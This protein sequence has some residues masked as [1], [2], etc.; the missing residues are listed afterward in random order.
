MDFCL[1]G[2]VK[3]TS[4]RLQI[5]GTTMKIPKTFALAFLIFAVILIVS[6]ML[7]RPAT[8]R[9]ADVASE[10]S[11]G[12][13]TV[14]VVADGLNNPRGLNF[15]PDGALYV[16]EAGS[17][18]E[19]PCAPGPEGERC[20]G[21]SGSITRIDLK[22]GSTE[23]TATGLPSLA[24]EDG[25]FANGIHD[26]SFQGMGNGSFTTGFGGH[27]DERA[28]FGD[29]G[30]DFARLGRVN[31]NGKWSLNED[32]GQYETDQDPNE[33]DPDSNPYSVLSLPGKTVYTDAGG[34]SLNQVAADGA[35]STLAVFPNRLGAMNPGFPPPPDFPP[36]GALIPMDAVPTTVAV[37]P[38]GAYYVGQLTGF[39]FPINDANVYRVPADGGN[40]EIY[41]GGFTAII[42]IAFGPDGSL[43]VLE[44]AKNSAL[45]GFV[46]GDWTGALIHVAAD[47]TRTE[48]AEGE[49]TAPGGIAIGKDGALYVTNNSIYSGT[50][51]VLRIEP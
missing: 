14:T 43:Y 46:F 27:P 38:D 51:Q 10:Q 47:G 26:I 45:A 13:V 40:P 9:S 50:G 19:G 2:Q 24:G 4:E 11:L 25:S 20:F 22:H 16:A 23:R 5:G 39:P 12:E 7:A 49:L 42:D 28:A 48:I 1:A 6:I 31:R 41:E 17:G 8:V 21:P 34:N 30:A 3:T 36:P 35:M 15:G 37:G 32:L 33:D 29:A 18:G 44:I